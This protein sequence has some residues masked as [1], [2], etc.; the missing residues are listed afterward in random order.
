MTTA[1]TLYGKTHT[2]GQLA[3]AAQEICCTYRKEGKL[4]RETFTFRDG[5]SLVIT[6]NRVEVK[7]KHG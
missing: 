6:N 7:A 1:S 5:S 4:G 2:A 3:R